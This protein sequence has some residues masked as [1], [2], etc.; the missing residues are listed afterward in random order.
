MVA[1]EA[2]SKAVA[3]EEKAEAKKEKQLAEL[4]DNSPE[5]ILE[6]KFVQ[7]AEKL[8]KSGASPGAARGPNKPSDGKKKHQKKHQSNAMESGSGGKGNGMKGA[9]GAG[10]G[11]GQSGSKKD[12][13]VA[14]RS[15]RMAA[16]KAHDVPSI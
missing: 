11:T 8:S 2:K 12:S 10:K 7:I 5:K 15:P 14:A 6:L 4:A 9:K 16:A 3:I 1:T 13:K